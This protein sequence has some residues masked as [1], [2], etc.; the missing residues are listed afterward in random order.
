L[1]RARVPLP[2]FPEAVR[3]QATFVEEVQL[4]V[5]GRKTPKEAVASIA[6]R[7]KPMLPA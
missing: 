5:L 6:E 4:A 2:A 3:A 1:S 7:V